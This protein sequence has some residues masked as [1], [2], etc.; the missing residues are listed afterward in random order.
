MGRMT[1]NPLYPLI[2]DFLVD[3]LPQKR[4]LGV[5]TVKAYRTALDQ[6]LEYAKEQKKIRLADV[7]FD[8]LDNSMVPAYLDYL[9][10][11]KICSVK[12][13][14][15][16]LNCL[17][18]FYSY[19]AMSDTS[20]VAYQLNVYKFPFKKE[21]KAEIIDHLSEKAVK[22]LLEQS[23]TKSKKGIRNLFI[24][25]LMY[26]TAARVQEI[27][28]LKICDFQLDDTPQIKLHGKGSKY[29]TVPLIPDTIAHY[30]RYTKR[31]H[32][33]RYIPKSHCSI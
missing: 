1:E 28:D 25:F 4:N 24:M 7:T 26:D 8:I 29:R 5:H 10:E 3:Y 9:E 19:A 20:C 14:N 15:H 23:D 21:E 16:R 31:F 32:P 33:G 17:R 2:H 27:I 18:A 22:A 30:H 6:L 11:I 13:R 12:T